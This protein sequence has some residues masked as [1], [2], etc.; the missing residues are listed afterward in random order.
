M[1][2]IFEEDDFI[3]LVKTKLKTVP[4][5]RSD[6]MRVLKSYDYDSKDNMFYKLLHESSINY[7][8]GHP[9]NRFDDNLKL[10]S[11]YLYLKGGASTYDTLSQNAPLPTLS[12]IK[13]DIQKDR[14]NPCHI[15]AKELQS[16]LEKNNLP[17]HVIVAEDATRLLDRIEIDPQ[18]NELFGL[19]ANTDEITGM[20]QADFF[21]VNTPSQLKDFLEQFKKAPYIQVI[22]AKPFQLGMFA[23]YC[24]IK[25]IYVLNFGPF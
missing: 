20:P 16:F 19:L 17:K 23:N 8:R 15:Y 10:F 3:E 11:T 1:F 7:K 25:Y 6:I 2:E 12:A 18:T 13:E 5:F 21:K 4:K 9:G 24:P 14:M 22:V